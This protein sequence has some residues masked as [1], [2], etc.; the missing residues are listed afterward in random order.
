MVYE[1][2]AEILKKNWPKSLAAGRTYPQQRKRQRKQQ[3]QHRQKSAMTEGQ[4]SG[5]NDLSRTHTIPSCPFDRK[6]L[7]LLLGMS[8]GT[9][10]MSSG[11]ITSPGDTVR[12]EM[13]A[14]ALL[15]RTPS[16]SR[17]T[18]V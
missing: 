18:N 17:R 3:H 16:L 11:D 1:K 13:C 2:M 5:S 10:V 7:S 14:A 6:P 4:R 8:L 9:Q 15:T 12:L